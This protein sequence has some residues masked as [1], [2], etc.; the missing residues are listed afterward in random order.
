M[1]IEQYTNKNSYIDDY[2][3]LKEILIDKYGEPDDKWW[4]NN[5]D[6]N[7]IVWLNDLYKD[8]PEHWGLAISMGYLGYQNCWTING[9]SIALKLSGNNY[10]I[11]LGIVYN[12]IERYKEYIKAKTE[13]EKSKL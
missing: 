4:L 6:Y 2:M 1:S 12:C 5:S 7:E 3:K 11:D 10:K 9:T 8:D 13:I